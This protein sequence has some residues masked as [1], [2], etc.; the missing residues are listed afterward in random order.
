MSPL[1]N[2]KEHNP[3]DKINPLRPDVSLFKDNLRLSLGKTVLFLQK[4]VKNSVREL[5]LMA[6]L[7]PC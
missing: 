2:T 6:H 4:V 5:G 7:L 1:K 3:P